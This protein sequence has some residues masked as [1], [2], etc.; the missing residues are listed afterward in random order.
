MELDNICQYATNPGTRHHDNIQLTLEL[1]NIWQYTTNPL[2]Q[3]NNNFPKSNLKLRS[4]QIVLNDKLWISESKNEILF[5]KLDKVEL[6]K[7]Y[8]VYFIAAVNPMSCGVILSLIMQFQ[9][10]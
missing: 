7:V 1:D 6:F 4:K 5:F 9:V 3:E 10:V 8:E 2:K